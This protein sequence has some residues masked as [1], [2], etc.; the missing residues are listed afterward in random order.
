ML[1]KSAIAAV[2]FLSL[3]CAVQA[4]AEGAYY[5]GNLSFLDYSEEGISEDPSL[6]AIYGRLGTNF[7]ENFSGEFRVGF[8][9]GDDSINVLG[10]D[11]DVELDSLFGAYLRGGIPVSENFFPYVV[12]G[13][14]RGEI[15]ASV[16][17]VGSESE[18]ETD[19][20][21]GLGADINVSS[22]LTI[23]LEYMNYF[24]KDGAEINGFSVGL[25][26]KF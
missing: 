17:G 19:A 11:A 21:F 22:N 9:V 2:G 8:G 24:D 7:N 18:S 6:T 16:S 12:L 20:S 13:Y 25:A 10:T 1:K 14:S 4:Y 5:G 3:T 15:T 23:N 26:S